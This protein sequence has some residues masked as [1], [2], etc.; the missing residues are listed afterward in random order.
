MCLGPT[1][2]VLKI[3]CTCSALQAHSA[4][5]HILQGKGN[6]SGAEGGGGTFPPLVEG[7]PS[8]CVQNKI[9]CVDDRTTG[10]KGRGCLELMTISL[11]LSHL[12]K[13]IN[14]QLEGKI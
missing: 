11:L 6:P 2:K 9:K 7:L 10:A 4:N 1:Q 8:T 13:A 5:H 14:A 3:L 12:Q